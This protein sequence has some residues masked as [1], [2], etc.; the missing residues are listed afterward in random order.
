MKTVLTGELARKRQ[1]IMRSHNF[2]LVGLLALVSIAALAF[3]R[4]PRGGPYRLWIFLGSILTLELGGIYGI[5]QHDNK[6]CRELGF[7][8]PF[9]GEPLYEARALIVNTLCPK[10]GRDIQPRP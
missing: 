2:L 9:C 1:Q 7:M 10:C 8:C 5:V 4:L 6:L 3:S